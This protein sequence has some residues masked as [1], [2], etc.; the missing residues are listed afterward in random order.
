[1]RGAS[2]RPRGPPLRASTGVHVLR[3]GVADAPWS[4]REGWSTV[5][6]LKLP[7]EQKLAQWEQ[8]WVG[9]CLRQGQA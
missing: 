5:E 2:R 3:D 7:P 4:G 6:P 1:M 9:A 8:G